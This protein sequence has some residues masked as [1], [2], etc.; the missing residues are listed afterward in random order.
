MAPAGCGIDCGQKY[1]KMAAKNAENPFHAIRNQARSKHEIRNL[2]AEEQRL[3]GDM[4]ALTHGWDKRDWEYE[5][6]DPQ[7]EALVEML[8]PREAG[9]KVDWEKELGR[10]WKG[11]VTKVGQDR[12]V[13]ELPPSDPT[14]NPIPNQGASSPTENPNAK[15]E[16]RLEHFEP[17]LGREGS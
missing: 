11:E 5:H 3:Y 10:Y 6:F 1:R 15:A 7:M 13:G 14:T 17:T 16:D 9:G 4:S 2:K 8:K 12:V